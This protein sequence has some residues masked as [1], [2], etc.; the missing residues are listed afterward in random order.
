MPGNGAMFISIR[1]LEHHEVPFSQEFRPEVIDFGPDLHQHIPLKTQGR[2]ELVEERRGHGQALEDIRVVGNFSTQ[3]ELRCARCLEP[4]LRDVAGDFDL[5]Y[6]P[7]GADAGMQER[8]VRGAEADI[9]YYQGEGLLLEDVLREQVLL[10]VPL[11]AVCSDA[12][13]GLC[14]R[15]GMNLN[16]EACVCQPVQDQR[17]GALHGIRDKLKQ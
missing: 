3:L 4:V 17:W 15:C 1:E 11:K 13:K 14:P 12:C 10:A 8:S 7:L 9:A 6:R 5:I 2:A 16:S